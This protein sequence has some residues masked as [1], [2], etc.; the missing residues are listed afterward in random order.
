MTV[1][2]S[3]LAF[4]R[5]GGKM[6]AVSKFLRLIVLVLPTSLAIGCMTYTQGTRIDES[7][8][9]K[10]EKGVTT[11]AEIEAMLGPAENVVIMGDGRRMME[12]RFMERSATASPAMF[13]PYVNLFAGG[14][15]RRDTHQALQI[16]L[17]KN[18]V[19]EDYEVSDSGSTTSSTGGALMPTIKT[20]PTS[21]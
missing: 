1:R 18:G 12:Y 10:I 9:S 16:I 2:G 15:T 7:Q 20:R 19:V 14:T 6:I 21:E 3:F 4:L 8:V 17:G 13:V 5:G 11:R